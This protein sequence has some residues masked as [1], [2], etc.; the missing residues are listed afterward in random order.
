MQRIKQIENKMIYLLVQSE[1]FLNFYCR[2]ANALA[3]IN[4]GK[5]IF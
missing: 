2:F 3:E 4:L 5:L 1:R